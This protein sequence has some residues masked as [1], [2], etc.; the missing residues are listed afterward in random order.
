MKTKFTVFLVAFLFSKLLFS[1]SP[2]IEWQKT[3]GGSI[4]EYCQEMHPTTDGGFILIGTTSSNNGDV[5]HNYGY[6][7]SS[8]WIIKTDA[9]GDTLWTRVFGGSEY[10]EGKSIQQTKDGGYL[11]VGRASSTD[12]DLLDRDPANVNWVIKLDE[13]GNKEWSNYI[14]GDY[15][16]NFD[17]TSDGGYILGGYSFG[18]DYLGNSGHGR[19]DYFLVKLD[20]DGNL[21]WSKLYGGSQEDWGRNVIQ[22][23]DKG[24]LLVG[25]TRSSDG[26]VSY[27]H[28]DQNEIWLVKTDK[29]GGLLWE[30]SLGGTDSD[31][32]S[33]VIQKTDSSYL[34]ICQTASSDGDVTDALG[35]ED[36]WLVHLDKNGSAILNSKSYGGTSGDRPLSISPTIDGGYL[37]CGDTYSNDNDVSGRKGSGDYWVLKID[38]NYQV[39]WAINLGGTDYDTA[40]SAEETMDGYIIVAGTSRSANG[41]VTDNNGFQ[42]FWL[43]KLRTSTTGFDSLGSLETISIGPNPANNWVQIK[44]NEGFI[45][46]NIELYSITGHKVLQI[47][48]YNKTNAG[49]D[50]SNLPKG[51]YLLNLKSETNQKS[52]K[53]IKE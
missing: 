32:A 33:D 14:N 49:I 31:H 44:R 2:V 18:K 38:A 50:I 30:K 23:K 26:D 17:Q 42:D 11:A 46:I 47:E 53:I 29:D 4:T 15:I 9:L 40:V 52:F 43:V 7:K 39:T 20:V 37:I 10:D 22:T 1:Q 25:H 5:T 8:M 27:N 41:D 3:Y 35:S 45:P 16:F 36:F 51:I 34:I 13:N 24:F 48:N 21:E 28:S 19:E 6:Q 12:Y